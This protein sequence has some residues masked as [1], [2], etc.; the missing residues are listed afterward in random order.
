M[1]GLAHLGRRDMSFAQYLRDRHSSPDL[2]DARRFAINFVEGFDAADPERISAK[3]LAEEQQGIGDVG[4][5]MQFRILGGYGALIEYCANRWIPNASRS[6]CKLRQRKYPG[7]DRTWR[8]EQVT[9][10][11]PQSF[12]R[13]AFLSRFP[14]AF[15]KSRRKRSVR[16]ILAGYSPEAESGNAARFRPDC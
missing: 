9:L 8:F 4:E 13:R 3:S 15:C 6:A 14:S 11:G 7:D 1:G 10:A 5:K 12:A 16:F 2:R